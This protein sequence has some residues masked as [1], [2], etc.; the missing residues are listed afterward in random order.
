MAQ[1]VKDLPVMQETHGRHEFE[2]TEVEK[3][4]W[5]RKPT[6]VLPEISHGQRSSAGYS[7]KGCK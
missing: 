1:W 6:Q 7:P 2:K 5:R 3:I 4:P